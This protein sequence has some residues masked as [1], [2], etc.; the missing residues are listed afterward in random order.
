[1]CT[2][3]PAFAARGDMPEPLSTVIANA[4]DSLL[5]RLRMEILNV[6]ML[7]NDS[8]SRPRGHCALLEWHDRRGPAEVARK[9]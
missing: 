1:M 9:P 2:L 3:P 5:K 8:M 7:G 6:R 4:V